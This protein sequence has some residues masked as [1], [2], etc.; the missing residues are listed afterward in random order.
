MGGGGKEDVEG[1]A[2]GL[3]QAGEKFEQIGGFG[4]GEVLQETFGHHRGARSVALRDLG[5]GDFFGE[6][7]GLA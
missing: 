3:F 5:C 4:G 6:A 7:A 2:G 1:D